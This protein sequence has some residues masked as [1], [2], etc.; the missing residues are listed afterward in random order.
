MLE[1]NNAHFKR[2]MLISN[3]Q[4]KKLLADNDKNI[5]PVIRNNIVSIPIKNF[6]NIG[7]STVSIPLQNYDTGAISFLNVRLN[8][9]EDVNFLLDDELVCEVKKENG[10]I[11]LELSKLYYD[12]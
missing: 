9:I 1:S 2:K 10:N 5:I 8:N 12:L 3:E 7:I 11:Y 4:L 6:S